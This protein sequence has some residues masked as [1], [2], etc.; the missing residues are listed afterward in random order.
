M[1]TGPLSRAAL[2]LMAVLP[3]AAQTPASPPALVVHLSVDQL[4]ADYLER[5]QNEFTGGLARLMAH[6]AVMLAGEQ[7]HAVTQ[8][9]PGHASMMSGRWPYSTGIVVNDR[10]VPDA[11][12]PLIGTDG[13]GASPRRFRGTTVYDWMRAHDSTVRV[14]SVSRK[15]RGAILPVGR[16]AGEV[17]WF[18]HGRFTTSRWYGSRLPDWVTRW[19]ATD[20]VA[21]L[22]GRVW[23]PLPDVDYPEVDA[24][25][26]ERGGRNNT[27]PYPLPSDPARAASE[28]TNH[29]VMDSLTLDF[30]WT[31]V[32]AMHLGQQGHPDFLAVSLSTTD[33]IGHRYGPGSLEVHDQVRRLDRQLGWFLDSLASVI[34]LDRVIISLTADHGSTEYPE[35]GGGERFS[36]S[37]EVRELRDWARDRW[38]IGLDVDAQSGLMLA[39]TAAL[40]ARGVAIDSLA[41][42][43]RQRIL[44]RR[45]VRDVLTPARLQQRSDAEAE[46]WRHQ[47]PP[48]VGWLVGAAIAPGWVYGSSSSSTGH[49]ST[50]LSDRRVP[51]LI[52]AAGVP[53]KLITRPVDVVDLAPTIAA[54]A[55]VTPTEPLDGHIIPEVVSSRR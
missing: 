7:N 16:A 36:L 30:A 29:P 42:A 2:S 15:D 5:W 26:V 21:A 32:R 23:T 50:N 3:L 37:T 43:L 34:P 33:A 12:Y 54:L 6:G 55:G 17:F 20:P 24:R 52:M 19:N 4:R 44:P 13:P 40:A 53:A 10:G 46:L 22:M 39:D 18:D 1:S 47:I 45:G 49:G 9:A 8:T 51:I 28:I 48:D 25:A 11:D 27:F 38:N 31:G 41:E 35:A 14:L